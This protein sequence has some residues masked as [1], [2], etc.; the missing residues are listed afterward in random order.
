[1]GCHY[2]SGLPA[3]NCNPFLLPYCVFLKPEKTKRF[4]DPLQKTVSRVFGNW[5]RTPSLDGLY[6][7]QEEPYII[8]RAPYLQ[9]PF[10]SSRASRVVAEHSFCGT[11]L[12]TGFDQYLPG[13]MLRGPF[14]GSDAVDTG[15]P[16]GS[17]SIVT[18][19]ITCG[20]ASWLLAL[21]AA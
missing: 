4:T 7:K 3:P 20:H 21:Q 18:C 5:N 15:T 17:C 16:C 12:Q 13:S 6:G 2:L 11:R 10:F 14:F 8:L 19:P 1:M 9:N